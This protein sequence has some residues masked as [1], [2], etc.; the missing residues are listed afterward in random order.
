[1]GRALCTHPEVH[2]RCVIDGL[3]WGSKVM[4]KPCGPW[5]AGVATGCSA[6]CFIPA[7]YVCIH[8]PPHSPQI[9]DPMGRAGARSAASPLFRAWSAGQISDL[10]T[11]YGRI[12]ADCTR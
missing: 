11:K 8:Q 5:A 1:M 6:W 4:L 12:L 7:T 3:I 2:A 10:I 9:A